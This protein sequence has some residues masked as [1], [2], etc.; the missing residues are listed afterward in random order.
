MKIRLDYLATVT[1]AAM[2]T[3]SCATGPFPDRAPSKV[4]IITAGH[5]YASTS[6][7]P[8]I[9]VIE[10]DGKPTDRPYGPIALEPGAHTV[11]M[12]CGD[13]IKNWAVQAAAGEIYQFKIITTPGVKGCAGALARIRSANKLG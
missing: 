2:L 3:A 12:K 11:T 9:S 13:T 6:F 8:E 1:A 10:V 5:F 7:G 4:A